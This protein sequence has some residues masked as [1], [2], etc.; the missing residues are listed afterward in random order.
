MSQ[1]TYT[2]TQE[3]VYREQRTPSPDTSSVAIWVIA[4]ALVGFLFGASLFGGISLAGDTNNVAVNA[5][6]MM[7][8]G[9]GLVGL[10]VL[11]WRTLTFDG[12]QNVS[13]MQRTPIVTPQ[14]DQPQTVGG[15]RPVFVPSQAPHEV[16]H[17]GRSYSFTVRQLRL[18]VDRVEDDNL[19]VA[20]DAFGIETGAYDQVKAVMSGLNYWQRGRG[21]DRIVWTDAGL[22]WLH[23]QMRE[24]Q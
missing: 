18:M 8:A 5:L 12:S 9:G 3:T 6:G 23:A 24:I 16:E 2:G 21:S 19:T 22:D 1:T 10:L 14:P 13:I 11:G 20:R 4:P 15:N 7:L 17:N